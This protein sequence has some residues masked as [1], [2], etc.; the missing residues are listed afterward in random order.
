[1]EAVYQLHLLHD[2][3]AMITKR[4]LGLTIRPKNA[5]FSGVA[6]KLAR[7]AHAWEE[8][9]GVEAVEKIRKRGETY[10]SAL[11]KSDGWL[12]GDTVRSTI[13]YYVSASSLLDK[14]VAPRCAR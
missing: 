2:D 1:M 9:G 6:Q 8:F 7:I 12:F 14:D 5:T 13:P 3:P 10:P 11:R 4:T